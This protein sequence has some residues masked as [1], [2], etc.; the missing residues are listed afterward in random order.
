MILI[1]SGDLLHLLDE[2]L[3][4]C[5]ASILD[6]ADI[7]YELIPTYCAHV[8]CRT[9]AKQGTIVSSMYICFG[10]ALWI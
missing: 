9:I 3:L 7:M 10:F 6:K 5:A 2:A 1:S 4:I 8:P